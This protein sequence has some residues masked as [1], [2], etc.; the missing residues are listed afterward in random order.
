[1]RTRTDHHGT[2]T[3]EDGVVWLLIDPTQAW[4]DETQRPSDSP[5]PEVEA[6]RTAQAV[7]LAVALLEDPERFEAL[8]SAVTN[9][10]KGAL[11]YVSDAIQTA[12]EVTP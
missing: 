1:M 2:W 3:S 8:V 4:F 11:V 9:T 5:D 12:A 7:A 6:M 10:A